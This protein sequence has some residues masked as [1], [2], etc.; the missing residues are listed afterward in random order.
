MLKKNSIVDVY[1][2]YQTENIRI[3][4]GTLKKRVKK[5]L[6]FILE[7]SPTDAQ[8]IYGYELWHIN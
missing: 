5:G 2:D 4:T 7:D 8:F 1:S 6:P 3:G